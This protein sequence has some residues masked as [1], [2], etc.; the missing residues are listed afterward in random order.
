MFEC[1]K[2]LGKQVEKLEEVAGKQEISRLTFDS[3]VDKLLVQRENIKT[4]F[5]GIKR[6]LQHMYGSDDR[7]AET[8]DDISMHIKD[9]TDC[10]CE[11][12][13]D[14]NTLKHTYSKLRTSK[15]R[16]DDELEA[17]QKM[18][19]VV[20]DA[21]IKWTKDIIGMTQ[22][23]KDKYKDLFQLCMTFSTN[24]LKEIIHNIEYMD[25]NSGWT[26]EKFQVLRF[27]GI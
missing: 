6:T 25:G 12:T 2:D 24:F 23:M 11:M 19:T 18:K 14:L 26:W 1:E 9:L 21:G 8:L 4:S 10:E 16:M 22:S 27:L 3:H 20:E 15:K 5:D 17:F 7:L 13:Q